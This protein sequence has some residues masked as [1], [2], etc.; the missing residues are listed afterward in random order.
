MA[1]EY[2]QGSRP[3]SRLVRLGAHPLQGEPW[4]LGTEPFSPRKTVE[5]ALGHSQSRSGFFLL[6]YR[7]GTAA[8]SAACMCQHW[9]TSIDSETP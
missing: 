9:G 2:F 4:I 5:V 1:E 8:V 3:S 6:I 7:L